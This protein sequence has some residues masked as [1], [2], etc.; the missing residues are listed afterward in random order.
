MYDHV[1]AAVLA[2]VAVVLLAWGI[3]S[4]LREL[5]P[6]DTTAPS[7]DPGSFV[8]YDVDDEPDWTDADRYHRSKQWGR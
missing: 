5:R 3:R 1:A 8:T 7:P 2:V 4:A 6:A